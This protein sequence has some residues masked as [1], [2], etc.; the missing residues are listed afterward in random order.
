MIWIKFTKCVNTGKV[1]MFYKNDF[2]S[3]NFTVFTCWKNTET[4]EP[5]QRKEPRGV[6]KAKKEQII[7]DLLPLMPH[8]RRVFWL[9]LAVNNNSKDL[10]ENIEAY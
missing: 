3:D 2:S 6:L 10:G 8:N 5:V 1:D 4:E 9:N 7:K